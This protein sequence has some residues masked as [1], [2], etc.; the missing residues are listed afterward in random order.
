MTSE[1]HPR[2]LLLLR[3]AKAEH[4]DQIPDVQRPLSLVGRRQ[5]TQVGAGLAADGLVP[6]LVLCSA[7]V[8][9]RQTWEL[10]RASLGAE[11]DVRYLDELYS[12]G[13][14][15]LVDLVR[16]VPVEV[17]TLL[18]IGHEPTM[19]QTATLLAGP[20]SDPGTLARVRIGVPT[21]SW[22]LLEVADWAALDEGAATLRR[23]T[24]PT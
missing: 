4:P 12:A 5:A 16:A 21:A 7:S 20:R 10:L 14:R 17:R 22:S 1:T 3:H 8:R 9:T 6:D 2:Q 24:I 18:V 23:L 15:G 19:S 11:P 13:S